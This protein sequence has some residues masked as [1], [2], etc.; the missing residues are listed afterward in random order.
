MR[1]KNFFP[2]DIDVL[3]LYFIIIIIMTVYPEG[4]ECIFFPIALEIFNFFEFGVPLL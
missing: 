1:Q 4:R 2:I 3:L